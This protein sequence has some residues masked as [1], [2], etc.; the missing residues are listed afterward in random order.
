MDKDIDTVA[1][2][3]AFVTFCYTDDLETQAKFYEEIIGLQ[4]VLVQ[5]HCRIYRIVDGGYIGFCERDNASRPDGVILTLVTNDVDD[6]C[7]IL[8]SKGVQFEKEPQHN[9]K[10]AIY[11]AFIRDPSG[12]L[13]EI[14]R[15]DD[16]TWN[17]PLAKH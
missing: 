9:D 10:F 3:D 6:F 14:Q 2:L 12:Y 7:K 15:F 17:I 13:L 11:H 4:L 1:K 8:H 16:P 5:A